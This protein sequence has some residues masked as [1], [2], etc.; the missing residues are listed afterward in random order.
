MRL[1]EP[2]SVEAY[3]ERRTSRFSSPTWSASRASP[4]SSTPRTSAELLEPFHARLRRHVEH[5]GGTVEKFIGDAVMAIFGAPVAHEDDPERAVR[6]A[7]EIRD[8][9]TEL[10]ESAE[11]IQLARARRRQHRRGALPAAMW[12]RGKASGSSPTSST[13]LRASSRRLPST[14]SS[15]ARRRTSRPRA[16]SSTRHSSRCGRR[17]RPSRSC[18]GRQSARDLVSAPTVAIAGARRSSAG[19]HEVQLLCD[20]FARARREHSA[21]LVTLVGR[22][23]IG[24]SRL[25]LELSVRGRGRPRARLLATRRVSAVR[26]G[27]DVLAARRDG[28]GSGR[29]PR[30]GCGR[31]GRPTSSAARSS[32]LIANE[33]EARWVE[34]HLGPLRRPRRVRGAGARISLRTS[35]RGAGSSRRSRSSTRSCS[36]SRISTGQTR[37]CSTS[38]TTSSTGRAA[39]RCSSSARPDRSCSCDAPTGAAGSPTRSRSSLSPL[40]DEETARLLEELL[41]Q[42]VLPAELKST[43]LARAGGNPLYA[44]E[45][46]ADAR[47]ASEPPRRTTSW[48]FPRR[49]SGIIAA[50]LDTLDPE[51]KAVLQDARSS[52]ACSGSARATHLGN[53]PRWT[54]DE[55]LRALER[56]QFVLRQRRSTVEGETEYAFRHLLVRDVAY[57]RIPRAG[58][59][60]STGRRPSGSSP[61]AARRITRRRC[62]YHYQQALEYADASGTPSAA[63][64]ERA[65]LALSEAGDRATA[66]K[67]YAGGS[68]LLRRPRSSSGRRT[69]PS[70]P[71]CCS[72]TARPSS[73]RR[74]P[75]SSL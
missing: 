26:R 40:S 69:T 23:G 11:G 5:L 21:Q 53:D 70:G 9:M 43:L 62:A 72:A 31:R 15:S 12:P 66:L 1:A 7:L 49:C 74:R 47:R 20:A 16:R 35:P 51:E 41:E 64:D 34:A 38:S 61:S 39:C 29:D 52:A 37:A 46:V 67:G 2:D 30:D 28:Q 6:A 71:R 27:R 17:E 3:E 44:E 55:R 56:K 73:M 59:P 33:D 75:E 65:R 13:S 19:S 18:A 4:T 63:L 57:G 45:F 25:V 10:A 68:P 24:K 8:A 36:S 22:P 48:R 50:R 42:A 32:D 58:A 54:I 14:A 60:R